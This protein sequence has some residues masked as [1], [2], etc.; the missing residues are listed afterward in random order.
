MVRAMKHLAEIDFF[1]QYSAIEDRLLQIAVA[2]SED[3]E[4]LMDLSIRT[5]NPPAVYESFLKQKEE[6]GY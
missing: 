4:R 3:D 6:A 1:A 2:D 5:L